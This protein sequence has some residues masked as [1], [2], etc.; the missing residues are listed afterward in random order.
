MLLRHRAQDWQADGVISSHANAAH[1]GLQKGRDSPLNSAEGIFNREGIHRK[2]AEIGD[3][4]PGEGIYVQL[5]IPRPDYRRLSANVAWAEARPW[6]ISGSAIERHAD[7]GNVQLFRLGN[8]RQAHERSNA[9]K[10]GI[11]QRV[12]RFGMGQLELPPG[13]RHRWAS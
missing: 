8:M 11:S 10:P 1:S 9:R 2:I 6:A 12:G 4:V 13:R 7:Q 5:R 3:A